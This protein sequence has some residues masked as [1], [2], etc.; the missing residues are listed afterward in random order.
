MTE[1]CIVELQ[2]VKCLSFRYPNHELRG[3]L[4]VNTLKN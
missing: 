2:G 4:I 3:P 1:I